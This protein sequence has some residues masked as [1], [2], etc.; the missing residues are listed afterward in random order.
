MNPIKNINGKTIP[1]PMNDVD[2]DL[3]IPAQYLTSVSKQGYGENLFQRLRTADS[4]FV[5]NQEKFAGANV[6]IAQHNF[7][8]GSSR[9]HAVWALQQGGIKAIIAYSFADIFFSNSAKNG[10]VLITLSEE[11]V[12]NLM[13]QAVSG[14]Y[15][16]NIDIQQQI[17]TTSSNEMYAFSLDPYHQ[18]CFLNGLDD[19]DY[20]LSHLDDIKLYEQRNKI[21]E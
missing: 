9:E 1:L 5:F 13:Q 3:I 14:G 17:L 11:I 10:L 16:V 6:L 19:M 2:T 7:G 20:L 15:S 21:Y 8:C 12:N 18:Y 4:N